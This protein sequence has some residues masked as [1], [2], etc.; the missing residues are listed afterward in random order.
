[1][2]DASKN[3]PSPPPA[4]QLGL[5]LAIALD[6][7]EQQ[8][9]DAGFAARRALEPDNDVKRVA[10]LDR[11]IKAQVLVKH[12]E[13]LLDRLNRRPRGAGRAV[14]PGA[15]R[16]ADAERGGADRYRGGPQHET[17][18]APRDGELEI[19]PCAKRNGVKRPGQA[20]SFTAAKRDVDLRARRKAGRIDRSGNQAADPR[21]IAGTGTGPLQ[22]PLETVAG[23]K[24]GGQLHH[25]PFGHVGR[26]TDPVRESHPHP[27]ARTEC[28]RPDGLGMEGSARGRV[29]R[30]GWRRGHGG[31]VGKEGQGQRAQ[32]EQGAK[33]PEPARRSNVLRQVG[34]P[35][36]VGETRRPVPTQAFKL[37]RLAGGPIAGNPG[38]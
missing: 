13:I 11:G 30:H 37:P 32:A 24:A 35:V 33:P 10:R 34:G 16:A 29:E 6:P 12:L 26:G 3:W 38:G 15:N 19:K 9:A 5:G 21:G 2:P 17:T 18:V 4:E 25:G 8:F 31:K 1:M 20:R 7:R 22:Q 36:E 28:Q 23:A 14:K 27:A